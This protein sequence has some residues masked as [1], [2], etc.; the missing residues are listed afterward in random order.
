MK[1]ASPAGPPSLTR[2]RNLIEFEP[3]GRPLLMISFPLKGGSSEVP[4]YAADMDFP[5]PS[6]LPDS[7][8][9]YEL[10]QLWRA[11][12]HYAIKAFDK[13]GCHPMQEFAMHLLTIAA[14]VAEQLRPEMATGLRP[15]G[16]NTPLIVVI[17]DGWN[18]SHGPGW[19]DYKQ[20]RLALDATRTVGEFKAAYWTGGN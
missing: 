14:G 9:L 1:A 3:D 17:A 8:S 16:D 19:E 6:R 5:H 2:L 12:T 11:A 18:H 15:T 7:Y 13:G 10:T 20:F 4:D